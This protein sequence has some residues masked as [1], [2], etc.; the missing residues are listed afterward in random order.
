M[1]YNDLK[2]MPFEKVF[3]NGDLRTY[4]EKFIKE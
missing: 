3:Y 2:G 1:Q 4:H